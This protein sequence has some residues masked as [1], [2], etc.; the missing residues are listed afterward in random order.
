MIRIAEE[1][2]E[3]IDTYFLD[4]GKLVYYQLFAHSGQNER[5]ESTGQQLEGW[6]KGELM[7]LL[8]T[9]QKQQQIREWKSEAKEP[10]V[11]G[12]ID[13][14]IRVDHELLFLEVKAA[15]LGIQGTSSFSPAFYL[16]AGEVA[17]DARKLRSLLLPARR[18]CCCLCIH[19][20]RALK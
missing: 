15:Y 17:S 7:H 4:T 9:L 20:Q 19:L 18:F 10:G 6:F 5:G 16:S 1:L 3:A 13:F 11:S 14:K 2:F 8:S 12:A